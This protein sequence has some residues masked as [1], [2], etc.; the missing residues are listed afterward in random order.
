[1]IIDAGRLGA[2]LSQIQAVVLSHGHFDHAA[3]LAGR[4]RTRSLPMVIHP[5]IW[6]RWRRAANPTSCPR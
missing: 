1:M 6:A 5:K 4:Q 3:G 2:D